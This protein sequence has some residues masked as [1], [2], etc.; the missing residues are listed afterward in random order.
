MEEYSGCVPQ[1]YAM[2]AWLLFIAQMILCSQG[3]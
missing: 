2:R 3:L 1:D